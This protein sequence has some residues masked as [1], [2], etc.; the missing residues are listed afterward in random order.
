M[1][2]NNYRGISIPDRS[3]KVL[4]NILLNKYEYNQELYMLFIDDKQAYDSINRENL[5]KSLGYQQKLP[6]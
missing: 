2:Y 6:E 3:Y 5:W 1:N 4:L